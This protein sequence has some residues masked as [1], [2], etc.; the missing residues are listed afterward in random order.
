MKKFLLGVLTLTSIT[1][2][3][4]DHMKHMIQLSGYEDGRS[5]DLNRSLDLYNSSGGTDSSTTSSY[6]LNYAYTLTDSLQLGAQFAS[7]NQEGK[8][9]IENK[10][11]EY[12]IFGIWNF[13]HRMTDTTYAGL[14]YLVGSAE[15]RSATGDKS[16]ADSMTVSVQVGHRFTLGNLWGMNYSWSPNLELGVTGIDPDKG[17]ESSETEVSLNLLKVDVLF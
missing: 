12:G 8:G 16:D 10:A 4:D 5:S 15:S 9:E 6:A 2:F 3:A 14:K 7:W 1:A 13:A 17:D 11:I